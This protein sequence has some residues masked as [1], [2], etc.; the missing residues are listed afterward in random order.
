MNTEFV[1]VADLG[2]LKIFSLYDAGSPRL[3]LVE[4]MTIE[5]GRGRFAD[6]VTDQAGAFPNMGS[7]GQAN[8]I[9]E[10][11]G[12][13]LENTDR[14]IR[15]IAAKVRDFVEQSQPKRWSLAAPPEINSAILG[16][17]APECLRS[18]GR[19][20]KKDLINVPVEELLGHLEKP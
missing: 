12:I 4:N 8:S 1:F 2:N 9:A 19:N 13:E 7:D 15:R 3:R 16:K 18:L 11:H 5:E 14:A 17:I 10:R 6:E 20:V